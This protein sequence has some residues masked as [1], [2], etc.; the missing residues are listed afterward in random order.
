MKSVAI[1][2]LTLLL[3]F[4]TYATL[5]AGVALGAEVELVTPPVF[6]PASH[7]FGCFVVNASK[8]NLVLSVEVRNNQ[9]VLGTDSG[10]T[11]PGGV[12]FSGVGTA[13]SSL[14]PIRYCHFVVDG[15]KSD[16]RAGATIT[17]GNTFNF[18]IPAQ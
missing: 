2:V 15:Q 5:L 18:F 6:L 11:L 1:A 12:R 8:R 14:G 16:V 10:L 17:S 9:A 3:L 7:F 4:G 13:D